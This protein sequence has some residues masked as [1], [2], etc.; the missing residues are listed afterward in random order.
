MYTRPMLGLGSRCNL[1]EAC[2]SQSIPY[3]MA[4]NAAGD[5]QSAAFLLRAYIEI[6]RERG[7][8]AFEEV[9]SS[10]NY[11][12]LESLSNDPLRVAGDS[13]IPRLKPRRA[14]SQVKTTGVA[15][16]I[17]LAHYWEELTIVLSDLTV[18]D[19]ELAKL[20]DLRKA[21]GLDPE[22]VRALHAHAFASAITQYNSDSRIDE[23]E[24]A[25]LRQ[26]YASL[27]RLGWA[28]GE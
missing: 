26:L 12:F 4:H 17:G 22:Q 7:L 5:A 23:R 9:A 14:A 15:A 25:N 3:V 21:F 11:K 28:P 6:A 13:G 19:E 24:R 10:A 8:R 18:T 1:L 27:R 2:R 20:L 16:K